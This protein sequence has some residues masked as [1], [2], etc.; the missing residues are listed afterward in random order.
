M[1]RKSG[2]VF[3]SKPAVSQRSLSFPSATT[4]A[5]SDHLAGSRWTRL[6]LALSV[7]E[8][9]GQECP[10]GLGGRARLL[11]LLQ[12]CRK[13]TVKTQVDHR[14]LFRIATVNP[15]EGHCL[16]LSLYL[17]LRLPEKPNIF[18]F[19]WMKHECSSTK[20]QL[21]ILVLWHQV[22]PERLQSFRCYL[23]YLQLA[24]MPVAS[25]VHGNVGSVVNIYSSRP[26][27]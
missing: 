21:V 23:E 11:H 3:L 25:G 14:S 18:F 9:M 2:V 24:E 19:F 4:S 1:S 22:W 6:D 27:G 8:A 16:L 15:K 17:L 10:R 13:S 5:G 20:T 26:P 12:G 7:V